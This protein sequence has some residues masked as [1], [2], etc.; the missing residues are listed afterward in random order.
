MIWLDLDD[1]VDWIV[2]DNKALKKDES[3]VRQMI[4]EE[5]N[6]LLAD[7]EVEDFR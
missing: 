1:N 4:I 6:R 7:Q 3:I 5:A 2:Y